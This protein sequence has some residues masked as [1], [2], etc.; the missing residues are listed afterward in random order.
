VSGSTIA[1]VA[2]SE[3]DQSTLIES[4]SVL[5]RRDSDAGDSALAAD[6]HPPAAITRIG[7]ASRTARALHAPPTT[8]G[9]TSC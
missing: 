5:A 7:S 1:P 6:G 8:R 9:T 4:A 2:V 3:C